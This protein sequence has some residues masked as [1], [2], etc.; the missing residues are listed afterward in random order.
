M[1]FTDTKV[2]TINRIGVLDIDE[3]N[4]YILNIES[5]KGD[6]MTITTYNVVKDIL[7]LMLGQMVQFKSE[8][9]EQLMG[10]KEKESYVSYAKRLTN[11]VEDGITDFFKLFNS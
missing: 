7:P 1:K 3:N 5:G 10:R 6:D 8:D 2:T 9:G 4:E 11:S